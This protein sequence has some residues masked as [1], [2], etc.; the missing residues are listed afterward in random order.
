MAAVLTYAAGLK[1]GAEVPEGARFLPPAIP[2]GSQAVHAAG[3]GW[4]EAIRDSDAAAMVY[5][6]DGATS[7]GDVYEAMN[8]AGVLSAQTVF[9]EPTRIYRAF[10]EEVP[11]DHTVPFGEARTVQEGDDVTLVAWGGMVRDA[12]AAA[13]AADAS[14][15]V[16]DLRTVFPLDSATVAESVRKT[17]RCVVVHEAHRTAGIGAEVIA[18]LNE[19]ALYYLEGPVERV[20][21]FDVPV[22]MF[23]REDAYR[24]GEDR[25]RAAIERIAAY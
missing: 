8:V 6:G 13:E 11:D 17:G 18:R 21:G 25:V 19:D 12:A 1:E 2:V 23:A 5:F 14:V 3:L 10:R 24:P 4:G 15:E 7:E 20:T 22:P 9:M 16:L